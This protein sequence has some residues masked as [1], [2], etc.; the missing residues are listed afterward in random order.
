MVKKLII[1]DRDIIEKI[2]DY[3]RS[4]AEVLCFALITLIVCIHVNLALNIKPIPETAISRI[5][6][7]EYKN[8]K[9]YLIEMTGKTFPV[10]YNPKHPLRTIDGREL[11]SGKIKVVHEYMMYQ[12]HGIPLFDVPNVPLIL[13]AKG[14]ALLYHNQ[15]FEGKVQTL[16]LALKFFIWS[17]LG[18]IVIKGGGRLVASN[19]FIDVQKIS[20]FTTFLSIDWI[21]SLVV[22][23]ILALI[24]I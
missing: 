14:W 16:R 2:L 11:K 13:G 5:E 23:F 1:M 15:N 17:I 4:A 24:W 21:L 10:E 9:L 3:G 20:S 22:Y 6:Y 18:F 19:S 12:Y 7:K 8:K